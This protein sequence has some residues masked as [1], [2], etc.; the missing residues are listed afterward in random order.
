MERIRAWGGA[1][2]LDLGEPYRLPVVLRGDSQRVEEDQQQHGPVAGRGLDSSPAACPKAPV[3][4]AEAATAGMRSPLA[5]IPYLSLPWVGGGAQV[6]E[7]G[8]HGGGGW[9]WGAHDVMGSRN[10]T[11]SPTHQTLVFMILFLEKRGMG[12]G[13]EGHS[14]AGVGGQG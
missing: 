7:L 2:T 11:H 6:G 14:A 10:H 5:E 3:G 4:S 12:G 13:A 8:G 9:R 1:R